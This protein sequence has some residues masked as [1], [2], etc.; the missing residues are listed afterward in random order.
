MVPTEEVPLTRETKASVMRSK[1]ALSRHQCEGPSCS[2][3]RTP[4]GWSFGSSSRDNHRRLFAGHGGLTTPGLSGTP[5]PGTY[6]SKDGILGPCKPKVLPKPQKQDV[7]CGETKTSK[8]RREY[9]EGKR[10]PVIPPPPR[11][12][13]P[14]PWKPPP[15]YHPDFGPKWNKTPTQVVGFEVD[16]EVRYFEEEPAPVAEGLQ[17]LKKV[18]EKRLRRVKQEES[19]EE[20]IDRLWARRRARW[21][22]GNCCGAPACCQQPPVW[23]LIQGEVPEGEQHRSSSRNVPRE[24]VPLNRETKASAMRAKRALSRHQCEGPCHSCCRTPKGWSFG[25]SSRFASS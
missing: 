2:C 18:M 12:P 7:L 19:D 21:R 13:P 15:Q 1:H 22:C 16:L 4:K 5:G 24:E 10:V 14:R 6:G 3:C 20:L 9:N 23:Y 17:L 11:P 8:Y 25:S